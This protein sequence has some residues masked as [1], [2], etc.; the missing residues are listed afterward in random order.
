MAK[1]C[2]AVCSGAEKNPNPEAGVICGAGG[3]RTL[4]Q[5]RNQYAFYM[6]SL[7]LVFVSNPATDSLIEPYSLVSHQ[8]HGKN[9]WPAWTFRCLFTK[10][11]QAGFLRDSLSAVP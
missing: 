11:R 4:V 7:L 2:P 1:V 9:P 10:N 6:L 8:V 5:T 3:N